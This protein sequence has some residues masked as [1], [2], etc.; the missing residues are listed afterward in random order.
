M[1]GGMTGALS[2]TPGQSTALRFIQATLAARGTAPSFEEI[3]IHLGLASKSGVARLV[4][5]LERRGRIRRLPHAARA[6]AV[7]EPLADPSPPPPAAATCPH[8]R[9]P[10]GGHAP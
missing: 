2:L 1:T 8:C 5:G 3:R 10:L 6:I 4:A 9:R 7:L